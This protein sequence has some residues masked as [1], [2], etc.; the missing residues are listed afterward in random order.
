MKTF[1][2]YTTMT[3]AFIKA[4]A[5]KTASKAGEFELKIVDLIFKGAGTVKEREFNYNVSGKTVK[6]LRNI[7]A[8]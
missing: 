4:V 8:I 6:L 7:G 1:K 3:E 5:D 2:R